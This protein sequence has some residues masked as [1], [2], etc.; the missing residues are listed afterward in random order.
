[1]LINKNAF[2][3]LC[4]QASKERWCWNYPCST[5]A[6]ME[7]RYGFLELA[8]GKHPHD[9]DWILNRHDIIC[10]EIYEF[11]Y[12]N[13]FEYPIEIRDNVLQICLESNLK[14]IKDTCIFP[15]WLGYIG[16][17]FQYMYSWRESSNLYHE[18][19]VHWAKQL[20]DIISTSST[21]QTSLA[22]VINNSEYDLSFSILEACE[23]ALNGVEAKEKEESI[24]LIKYHERIAYDCLVNIVE[25]PGQPYNSD[26]AIYARQEDV[27][28]LDDLQYEKLCKMYVHLSIN[29][30][31]PWAHFKAKF[32][33]GRS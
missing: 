27:D 16:L 26:V 30:N 24:A 6:N 7:F 32:L 4:E 21:V 28:R 3:A 13:I 2:E 9:N 18:V 31:T 25:N 15:N 5:C 10:G 33:N 17:V 29:S 20:Q 14:I 8:K 12:R 19:S 1:M 23:R 11:P 22:K